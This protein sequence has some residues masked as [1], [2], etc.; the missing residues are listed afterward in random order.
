MLQYRNARVN[1]QM[2]IYAKT[3]APVLNTPDF[4]SV[5]GGNDGSTLK[6]DAK[7]HVRSYEF[8][9][10]KGTT[11]TVI[12]KITKKTHT[13]YGVTTPHYKTQPLFID[14]RFTTKVKPKTEKVSLTKDSLQKNLLSLI[15]TP[16]V[17]G[18]NYSNGINAM[19]KYYPPAS[20]LDNNSYNNWMLKGVDCS[21]LLYEVT[22]GLTPR[23][24]QQLAHY[25]DGINITDKQI[26]EII[27]MLQPLDLIMVKGHVVIVLDNNYI[28]ESREKTGVIKTPITLRMNE[29]CKTHKPFNV[30]KTN[31]FVIRR[32]FY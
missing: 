14:S 9:A 26:E 28:I 8:V 16:Y 1:H 25:G 23:N 19:L 5:F 10:L 18:G 13:I 3:A 22:Q 31:C 24:T 12:K 21:G 4:I 20:S 32:W 15:N 30:M 17:W 6:A 11:F 29:I 2:I 7:G 27:A